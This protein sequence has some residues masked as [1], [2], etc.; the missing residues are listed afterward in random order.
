M[1]GEATEHLKTRWFSSAMVVAGASSNSITDK[2]H[3]YVRWAP[4]EPFDAPGPWWV[5]IPEATWRDEWLY[6]TQAEVLNAVPRTVA[7]E[8]GGTGYTAP[9]DAHAVYF[10]LYEPAV[11]H[12]DADGDSWRAYLRKRKADASFRLKSTTLKPIAIDGRLAQGLFY[13]GS[14]AKI[15]V[16]RPRARP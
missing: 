16:V 14:R 13:R 10:P 12:T 4:Y 11:D 2:G 1:A 3:R 6:G 15:P 8:A 7:R 5:E 9:P